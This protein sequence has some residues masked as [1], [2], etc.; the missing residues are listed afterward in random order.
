M[1]L[2]DLL[3]RS[4]AALMKQKK[5]WQIERLMLVDPPRTGQ[6]VQ[7]LVGPSWALL[8][9]EIVDYEDPL[10]AGTVAVIE[11][12]DGD[13]QFFRHEDAAQWVYCQVYCASCYPSSHFATIPADAPEQMMLDWVGNRLGTDQLRAERRHVVQAVGGGEFKRQAVLLVIAD[14]LP[15]PL[16]IESLGDLPIPGSLETARSEMKGARAF[17]D[18]QL[19][20]YEGLIKYAKKGGEKDSTLRAAADALVRWQEAQTALCQATYRAQLSGLETEPCC[21][22]ADDDENRLGR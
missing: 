22:R 4:K 9:P 3:S 12:C 14:D 11:W 21:E 13:V 15:T 16:C 18:T 5:Q 6:G 1:K 2:N 8:A 19:D 10:P 20:I 17:R 7:P